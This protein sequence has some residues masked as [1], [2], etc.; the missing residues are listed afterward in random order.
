HLRDIGVIAIAVVA[1]GVSLWQVVVTR[2]YG[3]LMVKPHLDFSWN[4]HETNALV[5]LNGGLG[6]AIVTRVYVA[7]GDDPLEPATATVW[8]NIKR[9]LGLSD[10]DT[11]TFVGDTVVPSDSAIAVIKNLFGDYIGI[12]ERE[13]EDSCQT[14]LRIK[15][16][17][18][19]ASGEPLEPLTTTLGVVPPANPGGIV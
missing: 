14:K 10:F 13:N 18:K 16:D 12:V 8:A 1:V 4:A 3:K 19:S 15:V 7:F 6:P 11:R 5:L 17:Y 9:E 2:K